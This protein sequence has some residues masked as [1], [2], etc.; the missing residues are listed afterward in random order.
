M[1]NRVLSA[2]LSMLVPGLGQIVQR[3]WLKGIGFLAGAMIASA[4]LRRQSVLSSSFSDG[5]PPHLLLLAV[6]FGLAVWSAVDAYRSAPA[7]P[8]AH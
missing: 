1:M 3:H 6:I 4:M 5:S 2:A 7:A 8:A